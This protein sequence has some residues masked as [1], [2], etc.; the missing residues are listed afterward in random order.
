MGDETCKS[1]YCDHVKIT[2]IQSR[3]EYDMASTALIIIFGNSVAQEA[4]E[5]L[6][7]KQRVTLLHHEMYRCECAT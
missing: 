1:P 5:G 3:A 4:V 2:H 7:G 6:T